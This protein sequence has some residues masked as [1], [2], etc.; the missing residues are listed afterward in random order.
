M[1]ARLVLLLLCLAF[2]FVGAQAQSPAQTS[3]QT[4]IAGLSM[5]GTAVLTRELVEEAGSYRL[6]VGPFGDGI[7]RTLRVEGR[8][9]QQ[10][11]RIEAQGM[12]TLQMLAP[13][14]DQ[15][16]GAGFNILYD[17]AATACGGFDFRFN[18][19]VMAAPD[20]FVDLLDYRFLSARRDGPNGVGQYVSLLVSRSGASGYI[21]VIHAGGARIGLSDEAGTNSGT[22]TGTNTG[23]GTGTG[24]AIPTPAQDLPL[25][26]ALLAWGHV[27]L[28][29]LEFETGRSALGQGPFASLAALAA[30]L[31]ED[32]DRRVALV[33]H[34]DSVGALEPN[35]DLSRARAAAVMT[36][37]IDTYG[38]R[39]EQLEARGVGYLA[40]I[41]SNRTDT[42]RD[43][44]RRVE[45]VLLNTE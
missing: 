18:T 4:P 35:I 34:T 33:G 12:T 29:D 37:L 17:C 36:R 27:R 28:A 16:T 6:P 42:G 9:V 20:M 41:A 22:S 30:F 39:P 25:A 32:D 26:E 19:R 7:M 1:L 11:W 44:N 43:A 2:P 24:T 45:A 23:T 15:L 14:R 13:L 8:I 38:V 3:A 31:A 40:P 21:Q 5:P 10:A